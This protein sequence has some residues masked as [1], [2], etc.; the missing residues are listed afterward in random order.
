MTAQL[1]KETKVIT[2]NAAAAYGAMLCRPDVVAAYPITPQSELI[3]QLAKFHANGILD[4]EYVTV[5]GENSAQNVVCGASMAGGR[6]FTA[7]S[8]YGLVYM[9]DAMFNT[10]GYRAPVVMINVN[11][12]PPGI[13]AVCSGQ[14]DMISTRD[15]GWVQL[16]AE[17]CQEILDL[18]IQGFRLAEDYDI[19]LPVMI[20]YDGYYLSFLA[21]AVEI[22]AIDEVDQYLA[23]LKDQPQR[24]TLI[25]GQALG[26]GSH[27]IGMGYVELRRRHMD[28][29][30]RVKP[31]VDA[32]DA[33]FAEKFGRSYGGQIEGYRTEDADIV[34][35]TSGSAVGTARTIIDAKREEGMK[36]GLV[37]LRLYRPFPTESLS[38]IL[39]GRKAIGVLDRSIC[40][41]WNCGPL[42]METKALTSQI[43]V[44]PMLSFIDGL[45]NMDI[46][47]EHISAMIDDIY[48]ASQGEDYKETTWLP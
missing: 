41:G 36:V 44:V 7:T 12:E 31:K 25:P 39:Q 32:I 24:P 30:E 10:A 28:A 42:F 34:L 5:E 1:T 26:C 27:G 43:G 35:V 2:G 47:Q 45:A 29:M 23:V 20:N 19:Q 13:H 33:E 15:T 38:Q 46:T 22:P 17:N 6:A 9:Y 18:T 4:C 16:I 48:R 14:Q 11:R 8:S 40:F 3:E 37:K 21:E